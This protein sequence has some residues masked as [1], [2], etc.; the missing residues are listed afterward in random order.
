M[1]SPVHRL[2]IF[3]VIFTFAAPAGAV[4]LP[5]LVVILVGDQVRADYLERFHKDLSP[6]GLRRFR[7]QG[8]Y[9]TQAAMDHA[10]TKTGP[11]HVLI[12]SGL[13]PL[14]SGIISNEWYDPLLRRKVLAA[15]TIP[16][17][18]RVQ[19]RW[20]AGPSLAQRVHAAFPRSRVVSLSFKDRGA[21]LLGGPDQDK[22]Y[23]WDKTKRIFIAYDGSEPRWLKQFNADTEQRM[24][25][26]DLEEGPFRDEFAGELAEQV[27][28]EWGL[29]QSVHGN[30]DVLTVS[31][32]AVDIVGH[33]FGPDSPEVKEAFLRLDRVIEKLFMF[34]E[35]HVG[36]DIVAV[37]TAD[38]GVTPLPEISQASGLPA[39]RVFID[40][41]RWPEG[42]L[43]EG[44]APPFIY[45]NG[46]AAKWKGLR[47]S[48]AAEKIQKRLLE[49]EGVAEVYTEKEI[50]AGTVPPVIA[51]SYYSPRP[52]EGRRCGDLLVVL[53]PLYIFSQQTQGTTHGQPTLDDQRIP[54]GFYGAGVQ[55]KVSDEPVSPS[56]IAPTLLKRLGISAPDLTA[57]ASI[58]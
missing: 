25:E 14:Q 51:K 39:G 58:F 32:S 44:I 9:F 50:L 6:G 45:I 33:E 31:F 55:A 46:S 23:W 48:Q 8:R 4:T 1:K 3:L 29:G 35:K 43:I 34:L 15:E 7:D 12:G 57:P 38:H 28:R 41:A 5:R 22:A 36:R 53:R 13:S 18:G 2:V 40:K 54:L 26:A 21:L 42:E 20:F 11:G 30:P 37:F 47:R 16:G 52:G 56:L 27:V 10:V 49:M 19:L 24:E 17:E